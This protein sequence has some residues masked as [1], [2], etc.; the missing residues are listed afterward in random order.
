MFT[1]TLKNEYSGSDPSSMC[2]SEKNK[3]EKGKV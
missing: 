1:G 3:D 2:D